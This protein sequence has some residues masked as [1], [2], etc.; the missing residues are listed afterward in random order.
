MLWVAGFLVLLVM[1]GLCFRWLI[2]WSRSCRERKIKELYAFL[3]EFKS[4]PSNALEMAIVEG[5]LE[6]KINGFRFKERHHKFWEI[7]AQSSLIH[8]NGDSQG[9]VNGQICLALWK[10]RGIDCWMVFTSK[11]LWEKYNQGKWPHGYGG[12]TGLGVLESLAALNKKKD[13]PLGVVM[14]IGC[15]SYTMALGPKKIENV[16]L[17]LSKTNQEKKRNE[18]KNLELNRAIAEKSS[19]FAEVFVKGETTRLGTPN[20]VPEQ[21]I[22]NLKKYFQIAKEVRFGYLGLMEQANSTPRFRYV[23]GI[24]ADEMGPIAA[25]QFY[26][27]MNLIANNSGLSHDRPVDFLLIEG[28]NF[29]TDYLTLL[30]IPFYTRESIKDFSFAKSKVVAV[31][32]LPFLEKGR[33]LKVSVSALGDIIADGRVVKAQDLEAILE[34][35]KDCSGEVWYYREK[36]EQEPSANAMLVMKSVTKFGLPITLSSKKDFSDWVDETGKSHVRR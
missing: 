36:A 10:W 6:E 30:T 23:V 12:N 25:S 27:E 18:T 4:I 31:E 16:Y 20:E 28:S 17:E 5:L 9:I 32:V 35:L 21:F 8:L 7:F 15:F 26:Q 19:G 2:D 3:N 11:H 1:L 22:E 14:N 13:V 34:R 29:I 33:K 24:D